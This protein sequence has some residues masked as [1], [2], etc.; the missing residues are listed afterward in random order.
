[1][2]HYKLYYENGDLKS[3][4]NYKAG[5]LEGLSKKYYENGYL[6]AEYYYKGGKKIY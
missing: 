2:E 6:I 1:M 4:V 5:K 3:E